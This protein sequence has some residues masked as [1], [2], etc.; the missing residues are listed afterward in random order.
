[1]KI[2]IPKEIKSYEYRVG[3]TPS[4]INSLLMKLPHLQF[5]IEKGAGLGSGF[6]D[7]SYLKAGAHLLD[8]AHEV[9]RL[10][11]LV[12]KVKEPLPSEYPLIEARHTLFTYFHFSSSI[13]LT[14]AML[15]RKATCIA[16]ETVKKHD[17]SLPL[18]T[19]MSEVAGRLSIQQGAKYLEKAFGGKGKLLGGIPGIL[20]AKVMVIGGGVVGT[21]A[22]KMAAGL[23]ARVFVFELNP[24][25]VRQL[26]DIFPANV[27]VL[28]ADAAQI[29]Q[30]L[31]DTDLVIGAVLIPGAKAPKVI[32]ADMLKL[33]EEGSV[34]VDVAIDQGGCFETSRPTTHLDPVYKE[35]GIVHY[36]VANMPGAVPQTSTLGLTY[37]TLPYIEKLAALGVQEA[38]NIDKELLGGLNI[39]N[40]TIIDPQVQAF[41]QSFG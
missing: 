8:H 2:G 5:F 13:E 3:M 34:L 19:P 22:A 33:M 41:Y 30:H 10:A 15:E 32:T 20:P 28:Y 25:R 39:H 23:G 40:G 16:Y 36:C 29:Q 21:Q 35:Q 27:V 14:R 17:G 4:G 26:Q 24:Q 9:Y 11:D 38:L 37:N 12:V 6:S 7:E 18:L 31:S 1:M